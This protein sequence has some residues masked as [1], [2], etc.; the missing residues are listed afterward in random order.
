MAEEDVT[1]LDTVRDLKN[2]E[3]FAPFRI[4][5]TSGDKYLIEDPDA[6]A[7]GGSRLFY[8]PPRP[9]AGVHMRL[10]QVAVVEEPSEQAK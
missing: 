7:I 1:T 2:R 10:N 3:P 8:Y 4:I 6:L 9:G 5:M